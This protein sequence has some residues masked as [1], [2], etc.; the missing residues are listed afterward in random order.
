KKRRE[1]AL[2]HGGPAAVERQ[3][4]A[5]RRTVRERLD[6]LADDGTF[7]EIGTLAVDR[8]YDAQGK[9]LEPTAAGYVMGLAEV[10]GRPVAVGGEDFTISA[11]HTIGL[12]RSKGGIGGFVE[13][14]AH[15]FRIPLLLC[16]EGVGGGVGQQASGGHAP[17]VS[18]ASFGR[19]FQLL[20]EVPVITAA[21][22]ACAGGTAA[23]LIL[24][25]FN[26]MTR[27]TACVFA[28]GPPVVERALGHR[29][30]KFNL[31][32]AEVHTKVSGMVDNVAV[33]ESD[34]IRQMRRVLGYLPQNVWE[35]P[36]YQ[37]TG[38]PPERDTE[39]LLEI[40]PEDRRRAYDS[41]GIVNVLVDQGSFFEIS[42]DW[43]KA[44]VIGLCRFGGYPAGILA[45]NP[46]HLGGALDAQAALKQ[47]RFI[48]VCDTFHIPL[49]YLVDVP[50]FMIGEAAE[51]DATLKKG[52]R[53]LQVL[54]EA[55]VPMITVH[56]RKAF[57]MAC[58]A[59]SNPEGLQLRVAWPSA[60]WGDMPIEGG[61]AAA[62][63]REIEAAPDP[64]T[65]RAEVEARLLK[66]A[67]PWG[68]AEAFGVEEIIDPTETRE[69][70]YRFIKASQGY[71]KSN[72]G[73]KHKTGI[74][75]F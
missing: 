72:L 18:S 35:M 20:G 64:D 71:I 6:E 46:M 63:R 8:R 28:G 51:R 75:V 67:S 70:I 47:A 61:V 15:E 53:A 17:L 12:D 65:Y 37:E 16:M 60:E 11:G 30:N 22:G 23:R 26:V 68:T 38:D 41:H 14:L 36:P 7:V 49:V 45:H 25:H 57:G 5:G 44:L 50:G 74:R 34:A 4:R 9:E 24:S 33:D 66:E 73:P 58:N 2:Q 69:F 54:M 29:V 32:G 19:S 3:R 39:E 62:F 43:G 48:E 1:R 56:T 59:T 10:D 52:M 13:D 55:T 42:P 27:D 40:M 21:M 31:G